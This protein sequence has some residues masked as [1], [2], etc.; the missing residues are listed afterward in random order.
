MPSGSFRFIEP[1]TAGEMPGPLVEDSRRLSLVTT[2]RISDYA[3]PRSREVRRLRDARDVD[4]SGVVDA[5][6]E[7]RDPFESVADTDGDM[8]LGI[9]AQMRADAVA[10]DA[11]GEYFIPS[12][13]LVHL[14]LP[15]L[16]A[17]RVLGGHDLHRT[18]GQRLIDRAQHASGHLPGIETRTLVH[19]QH[20]RLVKGLEVHRVLLT[21][22]VALA[23]GP[24]PQRM[25]VVAY[26]QQQR[27]RQVGAQD[28]VI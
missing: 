12:A 19:P 5:I 8:A 2:R 14:E 4:L 28:A 22:P 16:A 3:D 9:S 21:E 1:P 7:H 25:P 17:H 18:T 24:D 11:P 13:V 20:F 27:Q 15:G 6:P 10:V 26:G 23:G